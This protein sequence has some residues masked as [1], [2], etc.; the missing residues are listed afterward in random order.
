M[1]RVHS[2]FG[3]MRE[4]TAEA[5]AWPVQVRLSRDA[6]GEQRKQ[7]GEIS[8]LGSQGDSSA[9]AA[10]IGAAV[11]SKPPP[12]FLAHGFTKAGSNNLIKF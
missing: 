3:K 11:L 8:G 4:T 2:K 6:A 12:T 7:H 10:E 9:Q 5:M 1:S